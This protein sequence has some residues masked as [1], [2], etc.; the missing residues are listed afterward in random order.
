MIRRLGYVPL[1]GILLATVLSASAISLKK[2]SNPQIGGRCARPTCTRQ[3][4]CGACFC[5]FDF[6]PPGQGIC[7]IEPLAKPKTR[8]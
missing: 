4:D 8:K 1:F 7:M 2:L 5:N 6:G 3:S